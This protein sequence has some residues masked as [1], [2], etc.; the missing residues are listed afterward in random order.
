MKMVLRGNLDGTGT[1][2]STQGG[3]EV[4]FAP[5]HTG[6]KVVFLTGNKNIIR[7]TVVEDF[8]AVLDTAEGFLH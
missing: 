6:F 7:E 8:N 5:V 1:L 4:R 3:R 2:H